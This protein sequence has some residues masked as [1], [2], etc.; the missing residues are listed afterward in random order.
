[1]G[2]K[3]ICRTRSLYVFA[4]LLSQIRIKGRPV[5]AIAIA[6]V[7]FGIFASTMLQAQE[8]RRELID[9]PHFQNGFRLLEPKPGKCIVYGAVTEAAAAAKPAWD[10]GQWSSRYPLNAADTK[11]LSNGVF[12]F[13][14]VAKRVCVGAPG[15]VEAD[16]SLGVN[17]SAEY[18]DRA[19]KSQEEPWVHLLVQQDIVNS[20]SLTE[21]GHCSFHVEARLMRSMLHRTDD[22]TPSRH[23]AQFFIYLGVANRNPKSPGCGQYFWFGI[24]IYDD[25]SRMVPFYQAKDFGVSKMF[26]YTPSGDSFAKESTHDGQWVT[27][28]GDLLPLMREGLK[29]GWKAGFMP[30]SVEFADYRLTG[31]FMGWEVPGIFDVEMQVRDLSLVAIPKGI[32]A[33]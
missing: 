25:R 16:L 1:M 33:K 15:S 18:G 21:L 31:I 19:R 23:A 12:C 22:Y 2:M 28:A 5:E 6:A 26:I 8:T 4:L 9:D 10:I 11:R 13:S 29:A 3:P 7:W 14:N 27:F 24:P 32:E 30:G 20:P 17:A